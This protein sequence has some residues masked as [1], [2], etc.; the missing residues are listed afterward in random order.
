MIGGYNSQ[1]KLIGR[2]G[3]HWYRFPNAKESLR[4]LAF[5]DLS[6]LPL[7]RLA[8]N[9]NVQY[10]LMVN[11]AT[12]EGESLNLTDKLTENREAVLIQTHLFI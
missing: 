3:N 1:L 9:R 11:G 4:K 7:Q 6:K 2:P 8:T 5:K 10:P 12:F